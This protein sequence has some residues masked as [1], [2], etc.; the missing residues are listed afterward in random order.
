MC[1]AFETGVCPATIIVTSNMM[2]YRM[3]QHKL[4]ELFILFET[5]SFSDTEKGV[6]LFS[7]QDRDHCA[8]ILKRISLHAS[9]F[10]NC[11]HE[12]VLNHSLITSQSSVGE[13]DSTS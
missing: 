8:D 11:F 12:Y 2:C 3:L 13:C 4:R 6:L 5:V 10:G 7:T 9:E 1:D